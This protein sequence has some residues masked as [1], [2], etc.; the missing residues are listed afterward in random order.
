MRTIGADC[1]HW[2]GDIDWARDVLWLPF[3]YYKATDGMYWID[4]RFGD[5]HDGCMEYG[6][7]N[8]PYHW[9]QETQDPIV[10]AD[11]FCDTLEDSGDGYKRIIINVEPVGNCSANKLKQLLDRVENRRGIKPAIY[12]SAYYWS[13][14]LPTPAWAYQY[15]LL[16]AHYARRNYPMLPVGWSTWKIWQ[17][18]DYF[19]LQGTETKVDGNWFNGSIE[20]CRDWFGNYHPVTPPPPPP[21]GSSLQMKVLIDGLRVRKAPSTSAQIMGQLNTGDVIDVADIGGANAWAQIQAGPYA[22]Y[23]SAVNY[24]GQRYMEVV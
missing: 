6:I 19:Y 24:L 8:A 15:D 18:T 13:M 4:T 22:G 2:S 21:P 10:Q 14:V 11:H 7:P 23:W 3:V 9:W 12:T 16:V 1:S 20:Q 17:F 5:N